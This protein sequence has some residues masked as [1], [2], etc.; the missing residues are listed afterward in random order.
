M[1]TRPGSQPV[2]TTVSRQPS[3]PPKLLPFGGSPGPSAGIRP[4][5]STVWTSFQARPPDLPRIPNRNPQG[6]AILAITNRWGAFAFA[7]AAIA[8]F[9]FPRAAP[10]LILGPSM[11]AVARAAFAAR[12]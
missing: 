10:S 8:N 1:P 4:T 5:F 12:D 6:T 11:V 3:R 9:N 7:M 2:L